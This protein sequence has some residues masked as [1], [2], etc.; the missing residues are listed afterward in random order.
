LRCSTDER[1]SPQAPTQVSPIPQTSPAEPRRSCDLRRGAS[2][3]QYG[4]PIRRRPDHP[5]HLSP[6]WDGRCG[7]SARHLL[8]AA[9]ILMT[10]LARLQPL[11]VGLSGP[12]RY[13]ARHARKR[14]PWPCRLH[15]Q[16]RPKSGHRP[17]STKR[18]LR[19]PLG[20][21]TALIPVLSCRSCRPNASF[22]ELLCLSKSS[23]AEQ[24]YAE[25]SGNRWIS[26]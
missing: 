10:P 9:R 20:R 14:Y 13:Y 3:L 24:Y 22:A 7:Y 4:R 15:P 5:D 19:T 12:L 6:R 18:H 26:E 16:Q 11:P 25:R 8:G 21:A 17:M 2:I 23:V 1:Q